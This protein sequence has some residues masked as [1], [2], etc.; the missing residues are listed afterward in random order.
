MRTARDIDRRTVNVA[1]S[2][3][4]LSETL[5]GNQIRS[6]LAGKTLVGVQDGSRYEEYLSRSGM[7]FGSTGAGDLGG[8]WK[9]AGNQVCFMYGGRESTGGWDC[10]TDTLRNNRIIFEDGTATLKSTAR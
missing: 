9:I 6:L 4:A 7:I 3:A 10:S 5:S 2:E 1:F 8:Q